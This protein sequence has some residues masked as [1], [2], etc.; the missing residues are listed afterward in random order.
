MKFPKLTISKFEGNHLDWQRFWSQFE[1][2][3]DRAEFAQVT[4]F[5]FVNEMLKPKVRVLA[6]GLPFTTEGYERAKNILRSKYGKYSEV[7]NAH[8]HSLTNY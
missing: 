6:D 1:C 3:I 5:N 2:E 4:K 7:A 8:I